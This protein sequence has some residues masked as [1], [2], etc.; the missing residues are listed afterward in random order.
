MV[1]DAGGRL[2]GPSRCRTAT[3][4]TM[5]RRRWRP[6]ARRW[7]CGSGTAAGAGASRPRCA[8]PV[9]RVRP[10]AAV[11]AFVRR[12]C[13]TT[14]S[15]GDRGARRGGGDLDLDLP[16]GGLDGA[17]QPSGVFRRTQR[18]ANDAAD[19]P[20]GGRRRGRDSALSST[21]SS[22]CRCAPPTGCSCTGRGLE[23][24]VRAGRARQSRWRRDARRAAVTP[25]GHGGRRMAWAAIDVHVAEGEPLPSAGE[26]GAAPRSQGTGV[27]AGERR[28]E[29]RRVVG[30][31]CHPT[32]PTAS[33]RS[34]PCDRRRRR[35]SVRRSRSD[36]RGVRPSRAPRCCYPA[37][38]RW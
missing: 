9:R 12:P 38:G 14:V 11:S 20:P 10:S 27:A 36:R 4:R 34:P 28:A 32:A 15:V 30:N 16:P 23:A 17:A 31:A 5:R 19:A 37:P 6:A 3:A 13:C 18:L 29:R 35:G 8:I 7:S 1:F 22:T 25:A 24:A 33:R 21:A 2:G 26:L